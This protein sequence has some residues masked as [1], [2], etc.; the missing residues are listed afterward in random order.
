MQENQTPERK[1]YVAPTLT[2]YGDIHELTRGGAVVGVP[3]GVD[4][5]A[6][7]GT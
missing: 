4:T 5:F 6:S 7:S 1:P 2:E 3:D